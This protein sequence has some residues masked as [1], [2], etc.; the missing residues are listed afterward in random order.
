[1]DEKQPDTQ[2]EEVKSEDMRID[3]QIYGKVLYMVAL[4]TLGQG[5]CFLGTA[6]LLHDVSILHYDPLTLIGTMYS[7]MG[8]SF[9]VISKF[10]KG[11]STEKKS[12][13]TCVSSAGQ[14]QT[15]S[16]SDSN[17]TQGQHRESGEQGSDDKTDNQ[18]TTRT[19][20]CRE[21]FKDEDVAHRKLKEPRDQQWDVIDASNDMHES[22]S[23]D[24]NNT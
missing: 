24:E 14:N 3:R 8:I 17:K 9:L 23:L 15:K 4:V 21:Q 11:I 5:L 7:C 22:E 1:M 16:E 20:E 10:C 19:G 18:E 2:N 12:C 6:M 13:K